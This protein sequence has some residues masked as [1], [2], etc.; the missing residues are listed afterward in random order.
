MKRFTAL[1]LSSLFLTITVFANPI[2]PEKAGEIA[3]DFWNS[4]FQHAQ[5]EHLILQSPAKM[6]KAGSRIIIKEN[7]P[8]YYIYAPD[9]NKGFIIVSGDDALAPVIGYSTEYTG[10]NSEMP[11]ALVEWLNEY[12]MYVDDVRAGKVTHVQK[13][14][15]AGK[16]AVAPMLQTTWDQSAP[17]NNLCPEVN[18]QK[19]PTGCT[20]TAMA[21]IMKFH[22][23]PI[24]PIKAIYWTSNITG[25]KENI[26]LTKRTYN[27]DNMLPHY[28]NGYTAAQAHEVAQLMVDVG[29]AINSSYSPEG[30]GSNSIYALN[31]FV[32]VFD[33]SKAAR[34]IERTDVTE[35]EY[36]TAIREN[37]EARQPVM[38]VGY[39]V[40][41]EGGHAFVF[42]GIDENDM[43]H[44]DWGWSGAFNGYFDMTYMTPAGI[45][46]GGGTGTYNVG[47]AI[48][49]NI[50][51]SA[52]NDVNNAEPGLV[53]FG[54]YKP[55]TTEDPLYKY[56]AS[57][58]NNTA[59]F[60]VSAFV[61]NF[62]HSAFNN[63]EIALGV[64]KSNG[65]YQ[66]LKNVKF[67]GYSFEP[68]RYLSSNFFD[69]E[70]NNSNKNYYNYLEKGTHQLMLLYRNSD[71]ELT[72]IIS[73][74]NCLILDVNET[75]ATLRHAL[76]DIHVSSVELTTPNPRIGSTIKFNAKFI[77]KNTHN[78]NVLVVPII[79]TIR[80]DGSVVSDTL[81]KVTRLFE[82]IDNRDIYVEYNTSNQFKEVGDCYITFTY[83]WC[84][85]YSKAGTYNTSL[86]E[87]VSGKSDT[88]PINEEAPGGSPAI[89]AI[90]ASDIT[91]GAIL[92]VS[93]TV[94]NQTYAGYTYSADLALVL[95]N[96]ATN[97]TYTVAEGKAT[98]LG[99]NMKVTLSYKSSDYFPALPVGKY[100]I[101]VCETSNDMN[102]IQH[103]VQK[104]FSITDGENAVPYIN[105][106]T[107]VSDAQVVAGDS[108]DVRLTLGSHN[109]TFD[110]YVRINTSSGLTP[111]LRSN[112]IPVTIT[113]GEKL[114]LNVAC[115]CGSKATMGK[116]TLVIKYF[117]KNKRELGTLSN[118]TITYARND[119]FWVGDETAIEEVESTNEAAVRVSGNTI[120]VPGE[121]VTTIYSTDGRQVYHGTDNTIEVAKGMYIVTVQHAG[122]TTASKIFIK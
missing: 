121:A 15:K 25:K 100:E 81:K 51:P 45:G 86:A 58:S 5:A 117:D 70:I 3:S 22:E 29:K 41:Y 37:L 82:V 10:E 71:G 28:R 90:N 11:A 36:V 21:Q 54:I 72:E 80:P 116:W 1:L 46:T 111:I 107:S 85:D 20:A 53:E 2:D 96:T 83:N 91:N 9:N 104:T 42:D 106:R 8:Q 76:P 55:E 60:K 75:S 69:F 114:Q 97:Q 67:E 63:L 31:A 102:P 64:K 68:L 62:S 92:N 74:Q 35:D 6:A 14:A 24:T 98:N 48:I 78:S 115:L 103:D 105:G 32:N 34:I 77:N 43:I 101:M 108:V 12:S 113:E 49:V 47:Q 33:Y 95:R 44:I 87:S 19:T 99:K 18:G 79:N 13:S 119:Y 39:G 4:K 57:Y 110:G 94:T 88:F 50:A 7:N 89:T 26:D 17:Y 65:T 52:E 38:S 112:Y 118:N 122:T 93:A 84:S 73:D 61:A 40:N 23:W 66:I 27:W 59:K 16:T 120:T 109:G 30:T 56:T